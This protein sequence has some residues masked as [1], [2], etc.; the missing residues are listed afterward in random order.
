M[1]SDRRAR[2]A[3]FLL[4][5][6]V[7]SACGPNVLATRGTVLH[8]MHD[9]S[10]DDPE[11]ARPPR[12]LV[13]HRKE[14]RIVVAHQIVGVN[15]KPMGLQLL[16]EFAELLAG[17]SGPDR[18]YFDALIFSNYKDELARMESFS[19]RLELPDGR[20]IDGRVHVAA[21]MVD[22]TVRVTGMHQENHLVVKEGNTVTAYSHPEEVEN[23]ISLFSRRV[24]IE[25]IAD[26]LLTK[27]TSG[28]TLVI[29][30]HQRERRYRFDFTDDPARAMEW[31][32]EHMK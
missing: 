18:M 8:P 10:K 12:I 21:P 24:R 7:A 17:R 14:N 16:G 26:D 30:G 2:H 3:W 15:G 11:A 4:L 5:A 6:L 9:Q 23:E 31:W 32:V 22:H 27:E 19:Y 28:V 20:R 13:I 25:F 29:T 1:R